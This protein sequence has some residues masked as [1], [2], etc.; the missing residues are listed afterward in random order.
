VN[1]NPPK[2]IL[3]GGGTG[4][5]IFPAVAIANAIRDTWPNAE[6]LFVGA[7]GRMEMEKVPAAG[8]KIIGLEIRGLQRKLSWAN[9]TL[10]ITL[11]KALRKAGKI[12]DEFKPAV[13]IGVGGYASGALLFMATRKKIPTL[14]QEQNSYA[15]ITNKL[16]G[17]RVNTIC[18]A[19]PGMDKFF[20][21]SKITI[22]GNPVRK[23]LLI[24]IGHSEALKFFGLS[25]DKPTLLVVGGSLGARSVNES[26]LSALP[27]LKEHGI[28]LIWQTG[29]PFKEK[30]E[31]A[32]LEIDCPGFVTRAF[33]PEMQM[34]Y[35]AADLVVSRA[36]ALAVAEIALLGKAAILVPFPFASEDHQTSNA[37]ALSEEDAAVLIADKDASVQLMPA[38]LE[39]MKDESRRNRLAQGVK[40]FGKPDATNIIVEEIKK[41]ISK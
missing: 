37:K 18:V 12:I 11:I 4:G 32:L 17:K 38:I 27:A 7:K 22:S 14:I 26:I 5:H 29:S 21:A 35:A 3:S 36:G 31:K 39:L 2:F 9:L 13:A 20:P 16:L 6:I 23:E 8:Y 10:P 30:A 19:Y 1:L 40:K 25:V 41:L 33:I 24:P 28:Q 15:G 34:A